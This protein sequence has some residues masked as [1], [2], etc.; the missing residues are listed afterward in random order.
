MGITIGIIGIHF[1]HTS[2]IVILILQ[3]R[4]WPAYYKGPYLLGLQRQRLPA[5]QAAHAATLSTP[6]P[7]AGAETTGASCPHANIR[8][9]HKILAIWHSVCPTPCGTKFYPRNLALRMAN[10]VSQG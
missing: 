5:A 7:R 2:L 9:R 4:D 1:E 6:S 10:F 8:P 3:G